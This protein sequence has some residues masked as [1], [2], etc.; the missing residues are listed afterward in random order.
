MEIRKK[1]GEW[2]TLSKTQ[3]LKC[4]VGLKKILRYTTRSVE[5]VLYQII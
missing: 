2:R 3:E 4:K 5:N 1:L